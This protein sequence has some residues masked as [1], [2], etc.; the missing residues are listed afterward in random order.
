[1]YIIL[2]FIY[3][4]GNVKNALIDVEIKCNLNHKILQKYCLLVNALGIIMNFIVKCNLINKPTNYCLV[5]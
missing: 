3:R 4:T 2:L 1:M 5:Y